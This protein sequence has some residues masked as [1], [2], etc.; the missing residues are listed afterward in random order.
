MS[1]RR[2][3]AFQPS[4]TTKTSKPKVLQVH[5]TEFDVKIVGGINE[6]SFS[7][8]SLDGLITTLRQHFSQAQVGDIET[9][10]ARLDQ[11]KRYMKCKLKL[12]GAANKCAAFDVIRKAWFQKIAQPGDPFW[13]ESC[14]NVKNTFKFKANSPQHSFEPR[15]CS[16]GSFYD[17]GTFVEH[18]NTT[19]DVPLIEDQAIYAEF[20]HDTKVLE[21]Y[22]YY[23]FTKEEFRLVFEY[24]QFEEYVLV[25]EKAQGAVDIYLPL[26]RPP[27]VIKVGK[28][29]E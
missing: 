29:K 6:I 22:F 27:K 25:D 7:K 16:L 13:L 9:S 3:G 1:S 15:S 26:I 8:T 12:S 10:I 21:V 2:R 5:K 28:Y 11:T 18:Y 24:K 14:E 4:K 19:T 17:R 23:V 20:Q